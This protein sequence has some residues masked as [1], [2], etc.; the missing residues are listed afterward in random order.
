MDIGPSQGWIIVSQKFEKKNQ[1]GHWR[2][3]EGLLIMT[4]PISM[5]TTMFWMDCANWGHWEKL[6]CKNC[7]NFIYLFIHG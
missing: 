1:K 7:S 4:S 3:N 2:L 5:A 6:L